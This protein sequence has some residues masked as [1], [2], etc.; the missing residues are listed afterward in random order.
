MIP[1]V[2]N[3][4]M[5]FFEKNRS[6]KDCTRL[7]NEGK[8]AAIF[9]GFFNFLSFAILPGNKALKPSGFCILNSLS[10]FENPTAFLVR[11]HAIHLN[12]DNDKAEIK[13]LFMPKV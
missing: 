3:F 4:A 12:L 8:K 2:M 9:E 5:S 13:R 11:H 1:G 6:P 10:F 7:K